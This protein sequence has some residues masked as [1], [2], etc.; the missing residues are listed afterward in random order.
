[1][2]IHIRKA[3]DFAGAFV[4]G[5]FYTLTESVEVIGKF[6]AQVLGGLRIN[7]FPISTGFIDL[8]AEVPVELSPVGKESAL[9]VEMCEVVQEYEPA[10]A[11]DEPGEMESPE[12]AQFRAWAAQLGLVSPQAREEVR[13]SADDPLDDLEEDWEIPLDTDSLVED[14]YGEPEQ[15]I[16]TAPE[17]ETEAEIVPEEL[18]DEHVDDESQES[19]TPAKAAE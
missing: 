18:H 13:D 9:L 16:L 17:E 3:A 19:I 10:V 8:T 12:F 6:R 5:T 1:M 4:P 14:E 2:K 11:L 15:D 7:G